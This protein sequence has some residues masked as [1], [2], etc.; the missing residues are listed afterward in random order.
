MSLSPEQ[1]SPLEQ[2]QPRGEFFSVVG[3]VYRYLN[4]SKQPLL[5]M[6]QLA[7]KGMA[8]E[9]AF[10]NHMHDSNKRLHELSL[11]TRDGDFS[12]TLEACRDLLQRTISRSTY[13]GAASIN[14]VGPLPIG[15]KSSGNVGQ[16]YPKHWSNRDQVA[17]SMLDERRYAYGA[18]DATQYSYGGKL[19]IEPRVAE[20]GLDTLKNNDP[21]TETRSLG[22]H[23]YKQHNNSLI[24]GLDSPEG[25]QQFMK[26][27]TS[28]AVL[29]E[30]AKIKYE[31]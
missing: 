14:S 22:S 2:Y 11:P 6:E 25:Q 24:L 27:V 18:L 9:S 28:S 4:F 12:L 15:G 13:F 19:A 10:I 31:R 7:G 16:Q 29:L 21:D 5:S 30:A 20:L 1:E 17:A 26:F 8:A 23:M 3:S